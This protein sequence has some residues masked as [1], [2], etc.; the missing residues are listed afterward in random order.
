M[1]KKKIRD[2]AYKSMRGEGPELP[3]WVSWVII[4][5]VITLCAW[6]MWANGVFS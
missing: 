4:V 5:G 6:S 3:T 1:S 2:A